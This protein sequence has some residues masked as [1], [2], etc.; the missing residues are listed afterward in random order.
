MILKIS[1]LRNSFSGATSFLD[2]ST[3]FDRTDHHLTISESLGWGQKGGVF[4]FSQKCPKNKSE[5]PQG[6]ERS[7]CNFYIPTPIHMPFEYVTE[8]IFRILEMSRKSLIG[9]SEVLKMQLIDF[10]LYERY[11]N[12]FESLIKKTVKRKT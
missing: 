12:A 6:F 8:C 9:P 1:S 3:I 4:E 5:L 2:N 10:F 7:S 11:K